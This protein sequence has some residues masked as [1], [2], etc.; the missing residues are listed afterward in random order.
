[1]RARRGVYGLDWPGSGSRKFKEHDGVALHRAGASERSH[2]PCRLPRWCWLRTVAVVCSLAKGQAKPHRCR[3]RRPLRQDRLRG[4]KLVHLHL[5]GTGGE[6]VPA[7]SGQHRPQ[8]RAA[9]PPDHG[10]VDVKGQREHLEDASAGL[11]VPDLGGGTLPRSSGRDGEAH[12]GR[13]WPPMRTERRAFVPEQRHAHWL[14]RSVQPVNSR[15]LVP[16]TRG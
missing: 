3:K 12:V 9:G 4:R 15:R 8:P 14:A 1:M 2:Q 11:H 13:L 16:G 7:S 10:C 6:E 5:L